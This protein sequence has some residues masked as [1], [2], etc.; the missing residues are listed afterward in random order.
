VKEWNEQTTVLEA[1]KHKSIGPQDSSSDKDLDKNKAEI[2]ET[3][4]LAL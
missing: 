2:K 3:K 1:L 4:E